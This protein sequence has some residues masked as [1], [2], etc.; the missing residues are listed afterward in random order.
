LAILSV[1]FGFLLSLFGW[2]KF[3]Y[4]RRLLGSALVTTGGLI[5]G[6]GILLW[7]ITN[8]S[9]SWRWPL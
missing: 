9:W 8:Y 1:F 5:G 3:D 6:A 4:K 2:Q 7:Y